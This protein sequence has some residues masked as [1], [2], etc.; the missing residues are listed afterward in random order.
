VLGAI[1]DRAPSVD[2]GGAFMRELLIPWGTQ[3]GLRP[4]RPQRRGGVIVA[5]IV[6]VAAVAGGTVAELLGPAPEAPVPPSFSPKTTFYVDPNTGAA[7][8][9][10]QHRGD[11][12]AAG[13]ETI[14]SEPQALW[15]NNPDPDLQAFDVQQY[16]SAAVAQGAV[17]VLVAYAIPNR[18]CGGASSGGVGSYAD[19]RNWIDR[20]APALQGTTA[21]VILEP[22]SLAN[23]ACL[24]PREQKERYTTLMYAASTLH[25]ADPRVRV[26]FDGGNSQWQPAN[27]MADRLR[28]AGVNQYGDGLALN[29]SNFNPTGDEIRYGNAI[30]RHQANHRLTMVIDTSR[31][32]NGAAAS[33][34][35]CDPQG[36]KLGRR[37]TAATGVNRVDAYLWVK[38]PGQA[39]GCRASAGAFL[40]D[41]AYD[42]LPR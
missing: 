8:W 7:Q 4:R 36:R 9:V 41:Q 6:A 26:Y 23:I 15:L 20:I 28:N 34:Q 18:D 33:H 2:P 35:F 16:A 29:V 1:S 19:Y 40:P 31:N 13:I 21:V 10:R 27:V 22:D 14:A 39:D 3:G 37:P 25:G 12:R 11:P 42:L 32:G 24:P 17:P 38:H 30:L 5:A